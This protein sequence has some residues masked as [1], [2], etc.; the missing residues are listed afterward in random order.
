M[1][2]ITI[3]NWP[4]PIQTL[5]YYSKKYNKNIFIKRDDFSGIEFSGNK[6]RKLEYILPV[7]KKDK[8]N[9]VITVGSI[10]SN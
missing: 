1:D 4:T 5:N 9:T 2:K 3:G 6:V 7:L 10:Q 8:I